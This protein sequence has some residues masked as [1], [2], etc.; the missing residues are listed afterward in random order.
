MTG[1]AS[2]SP[3]SSGMTKTV[4]ETFRELADAYATEMIQ[5][6]ADPQMA[7][8]VVANIM[9]REAWIIAGSAKIMAGKGEPDFNVFIE[10]AREMSK[11]VT[12]IDP[13]TPIE[14]G[15]DA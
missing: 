10:A 2:A 14:G 11:T 12:F 9:M 1:T 15:D 13:T 5:A 6:G 8:S 7:G 4:S 3:I